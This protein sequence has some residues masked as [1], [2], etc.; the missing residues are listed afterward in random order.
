MGEGN[1]IRGGTTMDWILWRDVNLCVA[2]SGRLLPV[3]RVD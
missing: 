1:G 3:V 2:V